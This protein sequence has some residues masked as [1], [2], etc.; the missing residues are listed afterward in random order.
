MRLRLRCPARGEPDA[1][2]LR[3]LAAHALWLELW[4]RSYR[5]PDA[6][7]LHKLPEAPGDLRPSGPTKEERESQAGHGARGRPP[8]PRTSLVLPAL[9][10]ATGIE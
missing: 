7:A 9:E 2:A 4:R 3:R 8:A 10:T 5:S 6:R 1:D